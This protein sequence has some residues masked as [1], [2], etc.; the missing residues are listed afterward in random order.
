MT[1]IH[2]VTDL[3]II[4]AV[5]LGN[6]DAFGE[7][8]NRYSPK[9]T[10]YIGRFLQDE[11]AVT[12][13]LQDVFIKAYT[14]IQSF[15][16]SYSFSS[17]IYRIAHNEALNVI[18]KRKSTPF[19]W[20]EPEAL[21]PYFAYHDSIEETIDREVLKKDLESILAKLSPVHREILT[22]SFYEDL[23]YKEIALILKIP[24]SSV[25]V[26]INRAKKKAYELAKQENTTL[27]EY[28]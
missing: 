13:V 16:E 2:P 15:N 21:V 18:K 19:S 28:H 20:F 11:S 22:L 9:L 6:A 12:D 17:W 25:G 24:I 27:H 8:M 23:S 5:K 3:E 1:S 7:L 10:R 26:R 14:N 4:A